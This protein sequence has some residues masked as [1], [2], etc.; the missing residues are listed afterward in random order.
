MLELGGDEAALH[1]SLAPVIEAQDIDRVYLA[2]P[3]MKNLWNALPQAL[4]GGYAETA[5]ELT[6]VLIEGLQGGDVIMEKGSNGSK[7]GLIAKTLL[8]LE[9]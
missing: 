2:G 7:A 3:L 5:A 4:R 1:A 8:A 9:E 6:P